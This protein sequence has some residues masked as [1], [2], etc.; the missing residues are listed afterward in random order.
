MGARQQGGG[1]L[2]TRLGA[3]WERERA[4]VRARGAE[5]RA[6][7]SFPERVRVGEALGDLEIDETDTAPGGR[8]L[9]WVAPRRQV[10]L[11]ALRVGPGD[12]VRLWPAEAASQGG[13]DS[14]DAVRAVV[15]RR[16]RGRLGVV[17]DGD[18]PEVLEAGGFRLDLDDP[19][20]TFERGFRALSRFR[21]AERGSERARLGA[22]LAGDRRPEVGTAPPWTPRDGALEEAQRS[23]VSLALAAHDVALVHGPP[24]TGKTRT[25]AE[26]VVQAVAAGARV[27][28]TAASNTAVDNLAER[29]QARGQAVVRLGHP[30]RVSEALQARTLDAL[31]ERT[32]AWSLARRWVTEANALRGR[33][34]KRSARGALRYAERRALWAE[35]RSLERDARR[36][37]RGAQQG[38][39]D[40]AQVLCATAAGADASLLGGR[41]FDLVVLDEATQ[42]A[43]P[44]ALVPLSRAQRVVMAGDPRQL[45]P[46]SSTQGR[47]PTGWPPLGLSGSPRAGPR[48]PSCWTS[49]T[50]RTR[51]SWPSPR[52]ASMAAVSAPTP[53][54][55]GAS[56]QT[57]PGLWRILFGRVLGPSWTPRARA[58]T[59]GASATIRP[60]R[61]QPASRTPDR[62]HARPRRCVDC[63]GGGSPPRRLR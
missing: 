37:L 18:I 49:R 3:L 21:D 52:R 26:V 60:S 50:A 62:P 24:G 25:L 34:R 59:S 13:P 12:P 35:A 27:L 15:S 4:A 28:V 2:W 31:L 48:R 9:L 38:I 53:P 56:S 11:G 61:V 39:L 42:A 16:V 20:A 57:S 63:W 17:V 54:W 43:D 30:A 58:G 5:A 32:E 46:P 51:P 22:V 6:A 29:L 36:Q 10:D 8:L 1:K 33:A 7:R 45:P 47:P 55:R 44:I 23:A 14:P 19:E 41:R 40:G